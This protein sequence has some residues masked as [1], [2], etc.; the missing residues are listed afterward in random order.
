MVSLYTINFGYYR[1]NYKKIYDNLIERSK[2]R[3]IDGYTERHHIIPKCL[4]GNDDKD[5]IA[6]FTAREHYIAH[7]L[8]VKIY[9]G[10]RK[11]LYAAY[12]MGSYNNRAYEWIKIK[13]Y[14][15]LKTRVFTDEHR[16]NLSNAKKGR[17]LTDEHKKRI[18]Y[19]LSG[20]QAWNKG[21]KNQYS[22]NLSD[23]NRNKK[24]EIMKN[25]K[26]SLGRE[27]W[28]KG[29]IGLCEKNKSSFIE[30]HNP[31]N[32]GK[33]QNIVICPHCNKEGGILNMKRYHFDN[34]KS[35]IHNLNKE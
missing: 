16:I 27:P 19:S 20:K 3:I 33:K 1:M 12:M 15:Y 17:K 25:N 14:E 13:Q 11:L 35:I 22:I 4:G 18:S 32:K 10:N 21:M 24:S 2:D 7:Q 30:G 8:L 34:C 31:W 9:P 5:N 29:T 6:I 26:Y 28:N 23:E